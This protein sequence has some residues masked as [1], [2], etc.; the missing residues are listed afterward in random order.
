MKEFRPS[1]FV[2]KKNNA[3]RLRC[4]Q[5]FLSSKTFLNPSFLIDAC[6][7]KKRSETQLGHES[8]KKSRQKEKAIPE[9]GFKKRS[10][11]L[12]EA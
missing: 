10:L 9:R 6:R 7:K 8:S 5:H 12:A 4:P 1:P 11:N 2:L 3:G